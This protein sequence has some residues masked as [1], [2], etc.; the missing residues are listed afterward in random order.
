MTI[1]RYILREHLVP[2]L[3][4]FAIVT[5]LLSMDFIFDYLDLFITKGVPGLV[6]LELYLLGLGW[7]V[8]MSV[9]CAS[10]VAPLMAFGRM[11]QDNEI[12]ALRSS[13]VHMLRIVRPVMAAS[14]LLAILLTLFNNH[15]LP[16]T[17]HAFANLM[18]D[19]SRKKPALELQEG[20]FINDLPGYSMLF[21]KVDPRTSRMENV[22]I[23]E[24]NPRGKPT[25]IVARRGRLAYSEDGDTLILYLEDGEIHEVPDPSQPQKYRRMMFERHVI[26][27]KG[28]SHELQRTERET[29]SDREMSTREMQR[30]IDSLD[31]RRTEVIAELDTIA[32]RGGAENLADLLRRRGEESYI[33][34]WRRL[35]H[36][37]GGLIRLGPID[38]A[39]IIEEEVG[40]GDEA[41][42]IRLSDTDAARLRV[43]RVE[44]KA[45][46]RRIQ[47]FQVEVH[48]KFAI[49]VACIVF[50]LVGAPLGIRARRGGVGIGFL[51]VAFFI[52]YYICLIGG[53]QLADRS[54]LPPWL[55]MWIAN[56]VIGALG[57][58]FTLRIIEVG[59]S[60]ARPA[61]P[62]P[63]RA[64]AAGGEPP[65]T[66]GDPEAAS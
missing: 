21:G 61:P 57:V 17:N 35:A 58:A 12:T 27:V 3:F 16:R 26:Y 36:T 25:T 39:P 18:I 40:P 54:F 43:K 30:E 31:A 20:V 46:D 8:A 45:I 53:E 33:P 37:A 64:D 23:Y 63:V 1:D 56:V 38:H 60:G 11:A 42:P 50:V 65:A 51:S 5:F 55:A 13:G 59:R 28:V 52:F 15:A 44:L 32:V 41:A 14:V 10:L 22:T 34:W 62:A 48:K 49:P 9:P 24:L 47:S 66:A 7:M 2:F 29:K 19:I 6:V 4:G